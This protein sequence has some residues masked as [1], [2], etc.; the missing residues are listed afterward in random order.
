MVLLYIKPS[1]NPLAKPISPQT[2]K[3]SFFLEKYLIFSLLDMFVRKNFPVLS[4]FEEISS[5]CVFYAQHTHHLTTTRLYRT[6]PHISNLST[7]KTHNLHQSKLMHHFFQQNTKLCNTT[8]NTIS[9]P[10]YQHHRYTLKL[11]YKLYTTTNNKKEQQ[12]Q[13]YINFTITSKHQ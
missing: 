4:L 5:P 11:P 10:L 13:I 7:T 9:S 1:P 2:L 12:Q 8:P 6:S 3:L